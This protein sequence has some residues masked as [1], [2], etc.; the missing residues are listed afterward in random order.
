MA[1][2]DA[3]AAAE[4]AGPG[5]DLAA[6]VRQLTITDKPSVAA[7]VLDRDSAVHSPS[8]FLNGPVH[9][10]TN[11]VVTRLILFSSA[12]TQPEPPLL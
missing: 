7:A 9:S 11:S 2:L 4:A 6:A 12:I 8:D 3:S 5:A 1:A 10:D